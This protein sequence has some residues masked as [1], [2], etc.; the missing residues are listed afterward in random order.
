M[1]RSKRIA[2]LQSQLRDWLAGGKLSITGDELELLEQLQVMEERRE[3][4]DRDFIVRSIVSRSTDQPKVDVVWLGELAQVEPVKAREIAWMLLEVAAVA[5]QDAFLVRWLE[6]E[7][8]IA[9]EKASVMLNDFRG[10][11]EKEHSS[12]VGHGAAETH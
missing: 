3:A 1:T 2:V 9:K 7:V 6:A 4:A 10:Y 12:L 8:G 11:R 5:E